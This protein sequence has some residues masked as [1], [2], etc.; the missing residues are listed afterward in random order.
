[1]QQQRWFIDSDCYSNSEER[2]SSTILWNIYKK[3]AAKIDFPSK[4][5]RNTFL[6]GGSLSGTLER[7]DS[8]R[9]PRG[10]EF[11]LYHFE[12]AFRCS[13]SIQEHVK[14]VIHGWV[15]PSSHSCIDIA[16]RKFPISCLIRKMCSEQIWKLQTATN[17]RRVYFWMF[18]KNDSQ[19][20]VFLSVLFKYNLLI[21]ICKGTHRLYDC[22][23]FYLLIFLW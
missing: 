20:Y 8:P 9:A 5:A 23:V 15:D 13:N 2:N 14:R 19:K 1:M 7:A 17:F 12:M 3:S 11:D 22:S 10:T 18:C 21:D 6:G 16:V 4:C